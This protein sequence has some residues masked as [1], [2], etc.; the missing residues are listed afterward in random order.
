MKTFEKSDCY[1]APLKLDPD[2]EQGVY[3]E[4]FYTCTNNCLAYRLKNL[5]EQSRRVWRYQ[6]FHSYG[7]YQHK[8]ATLFAAL[9]KLQNMASDEEQCMLS[10][11]AKLKEFRYP[12]GIRKYACAILARDYKSLTWRYLRGMQ[13]D[14]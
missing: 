3:L 10:A 7:G 6:H 14:L 2:T 12:A 1:T 4:T 8:R 11:K 5:N 13:T 9:T